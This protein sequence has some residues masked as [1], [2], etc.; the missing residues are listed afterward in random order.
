[1]QAEAPAP[2]IT[3]VAVGDAAADCLMVLRS[4]S[5]QTARAVLEIIVVAPDHAGLDEGLLDGFAVWQWLPLPPE[6]LVGHAIAAAA[7][8]A[9][10][11]FI[12]Y[13]EEHGYF[14]ERWAERLI[15]AQEQGYAAVGFAMNNAN[16]ETL[17]SWAHLYGQFGPVVVPV[18]S[19]PAAFLAGHHTSYRTALLLSYGDLL[20]DLLVNEEALFLDL[21]ARGERMYL[22]GDAVSWHVNISSL[23]AYMRLDFLGQR[24]F[25]AMR[26]RVGR[27]PWWKRAAYAAAMPLV[28]W[29]R[30]RRIIADIYRTGRQDMLLPRILA[31]MVP[32]LLAG[33]V[34]ECLGYLA[35]AGASAA[36]RAPLEF[37]RD[38]YL[39][40]DDHWSKDSTPVSPP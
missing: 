39:A 36:L 34:G 7:R 9:R 32:A 28:P 26:A 38:R 19:R 2:K 4:L 35:G 23:P 8:V 5:R 25:A 27:W 17:T 40:A 21:R 16:P 29:V 22:A 15:A 12:T 13:A 30:L 31:P 6:R 18:A 20:G 10:A 24:G 3:V 33:A 37:H 11:P 1:M 14:H